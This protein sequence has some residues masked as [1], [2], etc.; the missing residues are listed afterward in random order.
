MLEWATNFH[1]VKGQYMYMCD[2]VQKI[3][4]RMRICR[5]GDYTSLTPHQTH[6]RSTEKEVILS[7]SLGLRAANVTRKAPCRVRIWSCAAAC[8]NEASTPMCLV[9]SCF[10]ES[11]AILIVSVLSDKRG[12]GPAAETPKFSNNQRKKSQLATQP[13]HLNGK[14][15]SVSSSSKKHS[16]QKV[17]DGPRDH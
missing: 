10:T 4:Y 14:P 12:V 7:S 15:Q 16:R 6:G 9:S 11:R 1:R 2:K 17:A 5:K 13:L 8:I 3:S